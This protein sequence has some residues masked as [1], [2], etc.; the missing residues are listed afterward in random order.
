MGQKSKS[1]RVF[2]LSVDCI[3]MFKFCSELGMGKLF[4]CFP[5]ATEKKGGIFRPFVDVKDSVKTP[6]LVIGL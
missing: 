2:H 4:L 6:K 3:V 1:R 5:G